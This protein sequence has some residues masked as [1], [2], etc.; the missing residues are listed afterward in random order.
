MATKLSLLD[1]ESTG[2]CE[3]IGSIKIN[4]NTSSPLPAY[5][6]K[7]FDCCRTF[8]NLIAQIKHRSE[9]GSCISQVRS[10]MNK[11]MI[12]QLSHPQ[13]TLEPSL[14]MLE[15]G[16]GYLKSNHPDMQHEAMLIGDDNDD[17]DDCSSLDNKT[18][19]LISMLDSTQKIMGLIENHSSL[20]L[21]KRKGIVDLNLKLGF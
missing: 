12:N 1:T 18:L 3:S 14:P 15:R 17:H 6:F 19:D 9:N 4:T 13:P 2:S 21:Q 10:N 8:P 20:V 7:C 5:T 11:S 16:S